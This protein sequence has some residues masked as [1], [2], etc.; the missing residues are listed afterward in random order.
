M[1]DKEFLSVYPYS[2]HEAKRL[3]ELACWKES[4][5]ENV[6]CKKAIEEAIRNGF[7]GMY[8][9]KDCAGRVIA[10]FGYHRVAYVLANSLQQKDYDGR[11]SRGNH[12]WAKQ[13]YIPPDKDAYSDRNTYFTV[14]SHPAVLDGFVN[15]YRRVYQSLGLFDYTHCLPDTEKQDFE[16]KVVVLSPKTLKE[17]CLTA[18]D[19]LWLC[20]GGFGS[21]AGSRGQAV[22][23]TCLADGERTRWNRSDIV[24]V[25]ADSHLPDWAQEKLQELQGPEQEPTG[26]GGMEMK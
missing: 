17:S 7:D 14:D 1:A 18:R 15:Q 9:D 8:L 20:T 22:F 21:H 10:E 6:A 16:G 2:F 24:G 12:D 5:K 26:M 23:A 19:Q 25:L 4:H 13:T 11:F 3:N